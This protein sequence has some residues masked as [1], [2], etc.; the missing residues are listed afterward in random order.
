ME[1]PVDR[2]GSR[3]IPRTSIR[4]A[5]EIRATS[6]PTDPSPMIST[7]RS[8]RSVPLNRFHRL[9]ACCFIMWSPRLECNNIDIAANSARGI[10]WTPDAVVII[11][12][13]IRWG[14]RRWLIDGPIPELVDWIQRTFGANSGRRS[15]YL[16]SISKRIVACLR[17]ANHRLSCSSDNGVLGISAPWSPG[18]RGRNRRSGS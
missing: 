15:A 7:V 6:E 17:R 8:D 1:S 2:L 16:R 10:A 13:G 18:N 3:R 9:D 14:Y 12:R 5:F 11:V 4:N